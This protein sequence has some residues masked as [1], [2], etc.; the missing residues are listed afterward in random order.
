[1]WK[2]IVRHLNSNQSE[3]KES[4]LDPPSRSMQQNH[5]N[6][7]QHQWSHQPPGGTHG[8]QADRSQAYTWPAQSQYHHD[9]IEN[10]TQDHI[11]WPQLQQQQ[12]PNV[13]FEQSHLPNY[14]QQCNPEYMPHSDFVSRS[15]TGFEYHDDDGSLRAVRDLPLCFQPLYASFR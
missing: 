12:N 11:T 7:Y 2:T 1:M 10:N 8:Q 13:P 3:V 9:H 14:G 6:L 5:N 4:I 15:L